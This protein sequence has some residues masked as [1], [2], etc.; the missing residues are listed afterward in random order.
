MLPQSSISYNPDAMQIC[1]L[2]FEPIFKP[3]VWGGENLARLLQKNLPPNTAIGE[4]WECA[5]LDSGQSVVARG[6]AKG[7][8]LRDLL[9]DWN[10]DLLGRAG[11]LE[12]RFPLLIKFLDAQYPL[13]IQVHP[14]A[15]AAGHLGV[16]VSPKHEAW[17]ILE[18]REPGIIY[19]GLRRGVF[20]EQVATAV[21]I[22]PASVVDLMEKI[23]VKAGETYYIPSGTLHALGAGV[24]VAEVQTPSDTTFRLFDWDRVRPPGDAGLHVS[25]CLNCL[26][27]NADFRPFEKRSHVTSVFTTVT[28]L[29]TCP[30]FIVERVRF[31]GG[32][33]QPIPYAELVIWIIL[34]GQGQIRYAKGECESFRRGEVVVLPAKI[35]QPVIKTESDCVWLEVTLPVPSDLAD[36]N[37]PDSSSLRES[38]GNKSSSI[39]LTI[40]ARRPGS[41]N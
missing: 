11:T 36:F 20:L 31:A 1:P 10:T 24:V 26:R 12:G 21:R 13:S 25:E 18:A 28:R 41:G 37:R 6:P 32:V 27:E 14:D 39:P 38:P 16:H 29:I 3:K 22:N 30:S 9:K 2:V 34:E 35:E 17:H 4:S 7:R 33:E 23:R 8:S 19:R 5:D 15:E 40:S